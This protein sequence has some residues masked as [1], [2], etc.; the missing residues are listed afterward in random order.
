MKKILILLCVLLLSN[1]VTAKDYTA[2]CSDKTAKKS[3]FGV[4]SSTVGFNSLARNIV[5]SVLQNELEK[6]LKSK[7]SVKI[8]NFYGTNIQNGEFKSLSAKGKSALIEGVYFSD[9]NAQTLCGYNK[10]RYEDEKVIFDENLVLKYSANITQEDVNKIS[11]SNKYKKII[12]KTINSKTVISNYK[13]LLPLVN[14]LSYPFNMDDVNKGR[15][16]IENIQISKGKME[17]SG[18]LTIYKTKK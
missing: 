3:F 16:D 6:E 18:Y 15:L 7:F 14:T 9:I 17:L 4:V 2:L 5:E 12:N 10:V 13:T 1:Y 8:N 11:S